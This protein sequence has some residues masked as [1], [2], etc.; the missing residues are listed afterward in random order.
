MW[1]LIEHH[2]QL[3]RMEGRSLRLDVQR[4]CG[5]ALDMTLDVSFLV[6]GGW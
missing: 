2:L 3:R 1:I 4:V 5:L 6:T